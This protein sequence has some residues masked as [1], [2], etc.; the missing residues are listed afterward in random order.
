[1]FD[2]F[3][4][5]LTNKTREMQIRSVSPESDTKSLHFVQC[6]INHFALFPSWYKLVPSNISL[7]HLVID[8][9]VTCFG[10]GVYNKVTVAVDIVVCN[11]VFRGCCLTTGRTVVFFIG[12]GGRVTVSVCFLGRLGVVLVVSLRCW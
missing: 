1:M 4:I 9:T 2:L 6:Q 10:G 7:D 11:G 3:R 12:Q 5:G 8:T